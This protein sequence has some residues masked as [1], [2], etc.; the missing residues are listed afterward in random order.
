LVTKILQSEV[1][2]TDPSIG[3]VLFHGPLIALALWR[4]EA[5]GLKQIEP[6]PRYETPFGHL[7]YPCKENPAVCVDC[8]YHCDEHD[9]VKV[10]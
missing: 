3:R 4:L 10:K 2:I 9:E 5:A 6:L 7:P 1:T 8:G